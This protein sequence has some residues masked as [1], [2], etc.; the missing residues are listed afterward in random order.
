MN[1]V[2]EKK[3]TDVALASMFEQDGAAG[4][5]NMVTKISLC[6]FYVC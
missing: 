2:T 4:M 6:H 1:Q 3:T 5:D